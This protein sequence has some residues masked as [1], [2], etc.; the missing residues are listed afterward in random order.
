MT[1]RPVFVDHTFEKGGAELALARLLR[2]D[3]DWHASLICPEALHSDRDAYAELPDSVVVERRGPRQESRATAASAKWGRLRVALTMLRAFVSLLGSPAV[4]HADVLVANTTR[5]SVYVA[6]AGVLLR[7]PVLVHIRDLIVP[8]AIGSFATTLMR[9]LVL[10]HVAG[11][12]AN[13]ET[14]LETVRTYLSPRAAIEVLPSPAGLQPHP[15]RRPR[16]PVRRIGL[17]ARVDPWKGQQLLL[18]SFASA[19]PD[20]EIELDFYGAPAFGTDGHLAELRAQARAAGVS[21]R[22]NFMG[23]VDDVEGAIESLDIC[24]QCSI[25]PEPMGQNVLQYL[26]AGK[27]VIVADEGGPAEWVEDGV[28]G[29]VFSARDASSLAKALS[30]LVNDE[31]LRASI[32]SASFQ[33]PGLLRDDDVANRIRKLVSTVARGR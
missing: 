27:A 33:T 10:P 6:A 29:L 28:N 9:R 15:P 13:S 24:V 2:V 3:I 20:G 16:G 30:R 17:V 22:V 8:E 19:F 26:A 4:R 23:H 14:S 32:A 12:I 5:S 1:L 18:S 11:V 25:R 7:K 21:S 31:D